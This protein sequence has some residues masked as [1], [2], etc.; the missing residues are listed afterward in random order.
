[1]GSLYHNY[2]DDFVLSLVNLEYSSKRPT[3]G[4]HSIFLDQNDVSNSHVSHR[5]VP[6]VEFVKS[7]N[8]FNGPSFPEVVDDVLAQRPTAK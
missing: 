5:E 1:M 8:I 2:S 7:R 4:E 6:L 3:R